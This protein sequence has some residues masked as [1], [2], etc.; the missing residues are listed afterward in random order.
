MEVKVQCQCGVKF[1]F[2]VEPV[3]GRMPCALLCPKCGADATASA[4]AVIAQRLTPLT[5]IPVAAPAAPALTSSL[6]AMPPPPAIADPAA[7]VSS[8]ALSSPSATPPA[9][10]APVAS[11]EG[12]RLRINRS[13]APATSAPAGSPASNIPPLNIPNFKPLD[14]SAIPAGGRTPGAKAAAK[15]T[16]GLQSL[17]NL[18]NWGPLRGLKLDLKSVWIILAVLYGLYSF[19][20]KWY[21][22]YR[23]ATHT[24]HGISGSADEAGAWTLPEYGGV[25][26]LVKHADPNAVAEACVDYSREVAKKPLSATPVADLMEA[27]TEGRYVIHPP[28]NGCVEVEGPSSWDG[29]Q[30]AA[31]QSMAEHV[32]RKLNVLAIAAVLAEDA[33]W[34][35]FAVYE[36]GER[37]FLCE[38]T[39]VAAGRKL[40]AVVKVEGEA[41]AGTAGFKPGKGG[42]PG[43]T[44]EDANSL[45]HQLGLKLTDRPEPK[46]GI[47]LKDSKAP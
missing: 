31:A 34:G 14:P 39:L 28:H 43:F 47:V 25:M 44:M 4:N 12:G 5:A 26:V 13:H 33:E 42:Y 17:G 37:R 45:T 21:H 36:R 7:M 29:A 3:N 8:P 9:L 18:G 32:S 15:P 22:R 35:T 24:L 20:S 38:R 46:G 27:G 16:G 19:G 30:L 40:Q 11:P 10:A 41:W 2:A 1:A 6:G 23:D